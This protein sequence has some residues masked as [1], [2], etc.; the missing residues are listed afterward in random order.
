[1][2]LQTNLAELELSSKV[3]LES[4]ITERQSTIDQLIKA[5]EEIENEVHIL[6][7]VKSKMLS[8]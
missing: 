3:E 1:M 7:S 6:C 5:K 8:R 4:A 2:C